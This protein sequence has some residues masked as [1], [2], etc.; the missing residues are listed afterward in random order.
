MRETTDRIIRTAKQLS[1]TDALLES[2]DNEYRSMRGKLIGVSSYPDFLNTLYSG[3]NS[4]QMVLGDLFEYIVAG[5][6]YWLAAESPEKFKDYIRI[7]LYL[8]N[9][10]LIQE[11]VFSARIPQRKLV[12]EQL[13]EQKIQDFFSSIDEE[14]L[15]D[16]FI[17]SSDR[18]TV[19]GETRKLYKVMDSLTPKPIGVAIELIVYIY[20]LN[21]RVGYIVPLLLSQRLFGG[22]MLIAPPDYLVLLGKGQGLG[23]EVGG[24]MGQYSLTQGKLEQ[25][26]LFIQE[27][28]LPVITAGVPHLYRCE[29]CNCWLTFC[30]EIIAR[31]ASGES[32]QES[33]SCVTCSNFADGKCED[34][35][36]YGQIQ[37]SGD[38]RRHHYNHYL[39][40]PYVQTK[41][42]SDDKAKAS[43]LI[44]Y[45]PVVKGLDQLPRF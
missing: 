5:R 14:E 32:N 13:K 21:R 42:L 1:V 3:Q 36:Y 39:T 28:G 40:H 45:F 2:A 38:R 17:S 8:I 37:P 34:I 18:I 4:R 24:G 19:T 31:T 11:S 7:I 22:K 10:V 30:E 25:A 26:N 41:G 15:Y 16:E 44:Q 27:T 9:L 20:L 23:I 33:I 29:T 12:L 43:K 35:I 6:G